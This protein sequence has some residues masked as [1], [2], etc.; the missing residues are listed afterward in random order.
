MEGAGKGFI[1]KKDNIYRVNFYPDH[2]E[3][4]FYYC[5]HRFIL[6]TKGK[7]FDKTQTKIK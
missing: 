7:Y 4:L 5:Y 2:K 3:C 6:Y 1:D